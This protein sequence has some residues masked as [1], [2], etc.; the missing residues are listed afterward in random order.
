MYYIKPITH[1][2]F[3]RVCKRLK[4][5]KGIEGDRYLV[6]KR[7]KVQR[8][9]FIPVYEVVGGKLKRTNEHRGSLY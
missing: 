5:F 4:D 7:S 9:E 3:T 8:F 6:R 1:G 2:S